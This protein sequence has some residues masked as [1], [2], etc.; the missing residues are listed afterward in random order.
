MLGKV[1]RDFIKYNYL[2]WQWDSYNSKSFCRKLPPYVHLYSSYSLFLEL[3][4][5]LETTFYATACHPKYYLVI[6][7]KLH[8][9]SIRRYDK[10][11]SWE[12]G[13]EFLSNSGLANCFEPSDVVKMVANATQLINDYKKDLDKVVDDVS[14]AVPKWLAGVTYSVPRDADDVLASCFRISSKPSMMR[15]TRWRN[16]S[17]WWSSTTSTGQR[18]ISG[19][20]AMCILEQWIIVATL[21][22]F[23]FNGFD[24]LGANPV[25]KCE[26]VNHT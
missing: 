10:L 18:R 21:W 15:R 19:R 22:P 1:S 4:S 25:T 12:L 24:Q 5:E 20:S 6:I 8:N 2:L 3:D 7:A 13:Y 17:T 11:E 14:I 9:L 26:E 23:F 16:R